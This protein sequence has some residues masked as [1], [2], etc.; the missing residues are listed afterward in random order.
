[1][2]NSLSLQQITNSLLTNH[3]LP[4]ALEVVATLVE[5]EKTSK[6]SKISYSFEQLVGTWRLSFVTG[7]NKAQ[8]YFGVVLGKGYYLPRFVKIHLTY[9]SAQESSSNPIE[10]EN[11]VSIGPLQISLTGPVKFLSPRN[12]VA[13]D[14]TR[15][16][17]KFGRFTIYKG[18]VRGGVE[19]ERNFATDKISKQAFFSY[20]YVSEEAIAARGKGGGLALWSRVTIKPPLAT[21]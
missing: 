3:N 20:F 2:A 8:S 16:Q 1:M 21:G 13:F 15:M 19:T 14:F 6:K 12:I 5:A 9:R 10:V 7:T 11:Y 4:L 17:L 18:Y